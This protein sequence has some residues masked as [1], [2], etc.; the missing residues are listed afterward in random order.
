MLKKL[1][2]NIFNHIIKICKYIYS[3]FINDPHILDTITFITILFLTL[4]LIIH[5][6]EGLSH[7]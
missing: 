6:A 7:L 3:Y 5:A 4:L 2:K 1:I